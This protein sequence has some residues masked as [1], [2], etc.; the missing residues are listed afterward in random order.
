M[1]L[2]IRNERIRFL[3]YVF[4]GSWASGLLSSVQSLASQLGFQQVRYTPTGAL[5]R[6]NIKFEVGCQR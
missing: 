4:L 3:N 2:S 6:A 5:Y 1:N